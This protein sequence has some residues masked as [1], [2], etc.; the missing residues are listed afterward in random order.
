M[1]CPEAA[2][3]LR[4]T[5]RTNAPLDHTVLARCPAESG[6]ALAAEV[7]RLPAWT[8]SVAMGRL[9]TW[10]GAL[11]HPDIVRSAVAVA[12]TRWASPRVRFTALDILVRQFDG[13]RSIGWD[14]IGRGIGVGVEVCVRGQRPRG[15][16][17]VDAA[18]REQ[19]LRS[20]ERLEQ[21]ARG[22]TWPL[23]DA[24]GEVREAMHKAS[25]GLH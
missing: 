7:R 22:E 24:A 21:A 23:R 1:P 16:V 6:A 3:A 11:A 14:G 12:E 2:T 19:V 13:Q 25:A 18:L 20:L 9:A 15:A 17:S 5:V 4:A 8:D 10:T